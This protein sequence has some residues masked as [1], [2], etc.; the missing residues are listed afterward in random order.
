MPFKI[1]RIRIPLAG[2]VDANTTIT[3]TIFLD[4][5]SSNTAL[6]AIN[7][8]NYPSKRKAIYKNPGLSSLGGSN[9]FYM[10]LA[11]TGT[12]QLPVLLPIEFDIDVY[13]DELP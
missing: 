8:T 10:Q 5:G 12:K 3:P 2:A 1:M 13:E 11:W 4:D 6:D 7:N 9:N